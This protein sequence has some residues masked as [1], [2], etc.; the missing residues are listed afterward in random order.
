MDAMTATNSYLQREALACLRATPKVLHP[1]W[2]YDETGSALFEAITA[3]PEYYLTRTER[4]ILQDNIATIAAHVPQGAALIE[5]GSGASTK[6]R[7]LLDAVDAIAAYV[8]VDIS[9][10]FLHVVA[11]EIDRSYPA[12]D[13]A[14]LVGDL[15]QPLDLPDAVAGRPAL[16]FFP[17]ST[18]GN[19]EP[20]EAG[21]LLRRIRHWP[22]LAGLVLGVDL[23]KDPQVLVRAYDDALGVTAA[24]NRN[25]LVRLN[26]DADADFDPDRFAHEARWNAEKAR[27]EMHL[28]SRCDHDVRIGSE[29]VSFRAGES[30]H[31]ENSHKYTRDALEQMAEQSGCRVTEFITDANDWFGVAIL[32]PDAVAPSR[33]TVRTA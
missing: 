2:F 12:L 25:V 8:P 24:F 23:V 15:L 11:Q 26:R 5:L 4:K 9:E 28:V 21:A 31:T 30:I 16:G 20:P 10:S 14:P 29:T 6:T 18:L 13:V 32:S 17:G 27:I 22:N 1:K 7:I 3:L 33:E 19:L